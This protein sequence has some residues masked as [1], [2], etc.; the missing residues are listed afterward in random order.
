MKKIN[1]RIF[2]DGK[3]ILLNELINKIPFWTVRKYIYVLFGVRIGS[4]SRIGLGTIVVSPENLVIGERSI[5]NEFCFLDA[6]GGLII[7]DDVSISVFTKIITASHFTN[8]SDFE[9]YSNKTLIERNVWIGANAM[10]L[11]DTTLKKNVIVGA[12]AVF[13]GISEENGIY[14]GNRSKL[15]GYRKLDKPYNIDYHPY[16]R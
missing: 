11:N 8:S 14:V 3:Y 9:Y 6:R 15:I 7:G 16:F 2:S 4:N 5:I 13:K 12:G 10:L 1:T